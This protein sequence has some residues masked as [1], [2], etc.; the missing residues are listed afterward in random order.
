MSYLLITWY[1]DGS[2][3]PQLYDFGN[4]EDAFRCIVDEFGLG[5][6]ISLYGVDPATGEMKFITGKEIRP[7]II[8]T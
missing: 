3:S 6:N 2:G 1:S 8:D 7:Q 4:A 5:K